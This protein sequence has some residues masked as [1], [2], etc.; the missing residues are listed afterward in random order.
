[1]TIGR[2]TIF[3]FVGFLFLA[4][5]LH[6]LQAVLE[7]LHFNALSRPVSGHVL[8]VDIDAPSIQALGA[9]PW[10]RSRYAEILDRLRALGAAE[11]AFDIDFSSPSDGD[12]DAAFEQALKR[13][14]G[15]VTLAALKQV[16]GLDQDG[17]SVLLETR[18]LEHF[19]ANGWEGSVGVRPDPDGRIRWF[20][21]GEVFHKRNGFK[22]QP[23]VNVEPVASL[24]SILGAG[25]GRVTDRFLIDYGLDIDGFD[26]VSIKDLLDGKVSEA[27]VRNRKVIIGATAVELRDY[28]T[29]PRFGLLAG[30]V[31]Q[32]IATENLLQHRTLQRSGSWSTLACS[33]GLLGLLCLA[34]RRLP[35]AL[36]LL[37][38]AGVAVGSEAVA[39]GVQWVWPFVLVTA[40]I[41]AG[42]LGLTGLSVATEIHERRIGLLASRRQADQLRLILDRVVAD[43][44][45]GIVV[46]DQSGLIRAASQAAKTMLGDHAQKGPNC[47]FD[48]WLPEPL[49]NLIR[50][51]IAQAETEAPAPSIVAQV[52]CVFSNGRSAILDCVTTLS[53]TSQ[54]TGTRRSSIKAVAIC[55]TF[56]DVTDQRAAQAQIAEMARVD[57]L[58]GLANRYVLFE[59]TD[60]IIS[61]E[62]GGVAALTLFDLDRFKT[63]NDRLG[64]AAGDQL[65]RAVA[66]RVRGLLEPGDVAARLGGDEFAL[67][68]VRRSREQT[69]AF[70]QTLQQILIG[71]YEIGDYRTQVTTSLGLAFHDGQ[72]SAEWMRCA[73]AALYAAKADGGS[74]VRLYDAEMRKQREN[75]KLLEEDLRDAV[76]RRA[77]TVVYQRQVDIH[78]G[79]IVG[80]EALVRW[81]HPA[82]GPISPALFIP[83][84]E[85]TGLIRPL[86]AWV[87]RVACQ[88][89]MS[90]PVPI[91][92]SVNLSAVQLAQADLADEILHVLAETGLPPERLDLELTESM[93]VEDGISIQNTLGRLRAAGIKLSLDDFGTGYSSLSYLKQFAIDKVKIDQSFV[94]ELQRDASSVAII[95][96]VTQLARELGLRVNAEGVETTEQMMLL[97]IMGCDEVQGYLHGRPESSAALH[98]ALFEQASGFTRDLKAG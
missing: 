22:D 65:V 90:W 97:Q 14:D 20:D 55:L 57:A 18:P 34:G 17:R 72:D 1:M 96:A 58:S 71:V 70:I 11:V 42:L 16:V 92:V 81:M 86:G 44:F 49:A 91:K 68:F 3:S 80:V 46:V 83:A 48:V 32:A 89:A 60:A 52:S 85:R 19:A 28:F 15:L 87:L 27:E 45:A 95:R 75:S 8:L 50:T 37:S 9:W 64:H 47:R 24:A 39:I 10:R 61:E 51:T 41:H 33:F 26:H 2:L 53:R 43:N 67:V 82:R 74:C 78:Q 56:Q 76:Q 35:F 12:Q 25:S 93:L 54:T 62:Q 38:C 84:A 79:S 63:V 94:R 77:F 4:G 66:N 69:I 13:A 98:Q 73:D 40:P 21:Q 7:E 6:P 88:D 36:F 59:R 31:L 30:P 23:D 29:V 5:L